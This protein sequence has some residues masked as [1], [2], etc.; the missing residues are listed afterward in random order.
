MNLSISF[1]KLSAADYDYDEENILSKIDKLQEKLKILQ[2]DIEEYME[3]EDQQS[4]SE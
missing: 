4:Y 1:Y 3:H 2:E